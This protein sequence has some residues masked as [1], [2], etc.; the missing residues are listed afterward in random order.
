MRLLIWGWEKRW[1]SSMELK[2]KLYYMNRSGDA[3]WPLRVEMGFN[4]R[5]RRRFNLLVIEMRS[6]LLAME[7]GPKLSAMECDSILYG[8]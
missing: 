2:V 3:T 1:G 4:F 6:N 8:Q 5:Q 7:M